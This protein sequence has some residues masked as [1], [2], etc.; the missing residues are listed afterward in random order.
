MN[1][2]HN[3]ITDFDVRKMWKCIRRKVFR[4]LKPAK[5]D[6]DSLLINMR[7]KTEMACSGM[8][9]VRRSSLEYYR[10]NNYMYR[11]RY[12]TGPVVFTK[13]QKQ[14]MMKNRQLGFDELAMNARG[15]VPF[16]PHKISSFPQGICTGKYI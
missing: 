3:L 12:D 4:G 13:T 14:R 9:E 16:E 2:G 1:V 7:S 6:S 10:D 8:A 11:V 15:P 5:V